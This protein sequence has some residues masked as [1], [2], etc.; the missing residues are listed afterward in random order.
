VLECKRGLT[1]DLCDGGRYRD[2]CCG[3]GILFTRPLPGII[4][5]RTI[6]GTGTFA[7]EMVFFLQ[8]PCAA[9]VDLSDRGWYSFLVGRRGVA[10]VSFR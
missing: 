10:F 9:A 2:L 8:D 6:S 1:I 5:Y 4:L 3:D 7:A